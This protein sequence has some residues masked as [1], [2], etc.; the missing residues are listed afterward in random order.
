MPQAQQPFRMVLASSSTIRG[1][2]LREMGIHFDVCPP[3]IDEKAIRHPVPEELVLAIA[4]AKADALF[5]RQTAREQLDR[6]LVLTSDQVVVC[7]GKVL[8]KPQSEAQAREFI[9]EYARYA[10]RTVGACV[11]SDTLTGGRW[12]GVYCARV[13]FSRIP[14]ETVRVLIEQ[15]DVFHCAGGLMVEHPLVQS[16]ILCMEGGLDCVQGLC[17]ATVRRLLWQALEERETRG[18][19]QQSATRDFFRRLSWPEPK[20]CSGVGRE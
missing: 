15:G 19:L 16:S 3:N 17:K 6:A 11:L 7:N 10:P 12:T 13:R 9:G 1:Q 18:H 4:T 2:I 14:D 8:E 5:H 20:A